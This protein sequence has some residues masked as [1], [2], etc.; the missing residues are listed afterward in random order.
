M[1]ATIGQIVHYTMPARD[2]GTFGS[3]Y[4]QSQV[5]PAMIVNA[6]TDEMVN[7]RIFPDSSGQSWVETSVPLKD[8]NSTVEN[9]YY[10]EWPARD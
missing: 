5:V 4:G 1:K 6:F 10:W 3:Q 7:L 9:G 8:E 2:V